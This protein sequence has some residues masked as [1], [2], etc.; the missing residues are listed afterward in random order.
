MDTIKL[1]ARINPTAQVSISNTFRAVMEEPGNVVT[2]TIRNIPRFDDT[3]PENY[4]ECSSTAR[5]VF[6]MSN[7]DVSDVLN[8]SVETV[9]TITD[10]DTPGTPT[11]LVEIQ[12]W[13][14][15]CETL[16]TILYLVT[17]GPADK[18]VRQYLGMTSAGSLGHGRKSWNTLYT[19]YNSNSKKSWRACY[20]KLVN[21]V[22]EQGQ[23]SD[24]YAIK[25]MEIHIRL[26][27]MG[28]NISDERFKDI[29]LQGLIDD[30]ELVKMTSF[31]SRN[32]R[33]D[34]IQSMM[35]RILYID[36]LSRPE[37]VNNLAGLK[38]PTTTTK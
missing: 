5:V 14:R 11:N 8:G 33:T 21:F 29:L 7:K 27:E 10:R 38:S 28:E 1:R 3:K 6:S 2:S 22:M 13:E 18:L 20:E 34:E 19:K 24:D 9:P 4:R 12:R 36:Q 37:H 35:M 32:F 16:F 26:H 23:D 15:A 25:L 30:Y 31:H 17:S